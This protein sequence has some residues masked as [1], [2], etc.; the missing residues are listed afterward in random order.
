MRLQ[1]I[2]RCFVSSAPSQRLQDGTSLRRLRRVKARPFALVPDGCGG[3]DAGGEHC[4]ISK[5]GDIYKIEPNPI[6]RGN[7]I[8]LPSEVS[9]VANALPGGGCDATCDLDP[10]TPRLSHGWQIDAHRSAV[11]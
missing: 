10:D 9:D 2:R 7:G 8:L 1:E 11:D 4:V 5:D 3:R 6:A